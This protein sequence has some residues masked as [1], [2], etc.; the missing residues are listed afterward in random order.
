ME[1]KIGGSVN[2][3]FPFENYYLLTEYMNIIGHYIHFSVYIQRN[4]YIFATKCI[5]N[6]VPNTL[7]NLKQKL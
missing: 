7:V 2:C 6:Y 1:V 3:K 4:L 5:L